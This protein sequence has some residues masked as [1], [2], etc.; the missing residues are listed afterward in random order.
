MVSVVICIQLI[1][2][3]AVDLSLRILTYTHIYS[4]LPKQAWDLNLS[5]EMIL[6]T[7]TLE[8]KYN[9]LEITFNDAK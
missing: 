8:Y 7:A 5:L 9:C 3:N 2:D 6:T 1:V 4:R